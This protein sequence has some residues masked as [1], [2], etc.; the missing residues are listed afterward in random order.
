MSLQKKILDTYR[1]MLFT[2]YDDRGDVFYFS[3]TELGGIDFLPYEFKNKNGDTLRGGFYFCGEKSHTRIIIFEHGL[4]G[5]HRSYMREI[6]QLTRHGYTVLA[7]DHTGCMDSEGESTKGFSGSL[8]DLDCC[9]KALKAD[10]E[11]ADMDI[12]VVGHSWG[13]YSTLNIGAYHP[14]VTHICAISGFISVERMLEQQLTS[15]LRGYV[16]ML[17]ALERATNKDYAD[18]DAISALHKTRAKALIIHSQDDKTVKAKPHFNVLR[19]ALGDRPNT[20]FLLTS[21][22]RH[23]PNYTKDAVRYE[24]ACIKKL[25][26]LRRRGKLNTD[27]EKA[28]FRK[29]FDWYRMTAQDP[30]VW[31]TIFEFLDS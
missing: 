31:Q 27:E 16:P 28:A 13:G 22:K 17:L 14:D 9:I 2:R 29:S 10:R 12:S 11:Y 1:A 30:A 6:E 19:P 18:S 23:N 8:A 21:G 26:K 24:A 20:E 15:L 25:R 5:G 7:Y 4:G 3:H